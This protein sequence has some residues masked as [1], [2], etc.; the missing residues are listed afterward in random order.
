MQSQINISIAVNVMKALSDRSLHRNMYMM[1]DSAFGSREQGTENLCTL[2]APGQT[3]RWAVY[4]LDVQTPAAIQ[5][6]TFLPGDPDGEASETPPTGSPGE[7]SE[8]EEVSGIPAA[9]C[10]DVPD[11][12]HPDLKTWK[13]IV[14]CLQPGR[15]YRYRLEIRMGYGK[16]SCLSAETASLCWAC[17]YSDKENN[18][19]DESKE[20]TI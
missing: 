17:A 12:E 5:A 4:A 3:I 6:I 16:D 15:K 11:T 13:G 1:D 19:P 7:G 9:P 8:P 10:A 2:C 18:K 20:A 14:P